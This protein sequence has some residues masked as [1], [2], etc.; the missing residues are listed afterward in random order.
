MRIESDR[1]HISS[2]VRHG[3]TTGA[4]ITLTIQTRTIKNG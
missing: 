1:V 2:G 4:P 3:K